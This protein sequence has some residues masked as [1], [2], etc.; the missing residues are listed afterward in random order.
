MSISYFELRQNLSLRIAMPASVPYWRIAQMRVLLVDD[1][2]LARVT[3]AAGLRSLGLEVSEAENGM[4]A[5]QLWTVGVF[6]TVITDI[7]M[8]EL[9]GYELALRIRTMDNERP[10]LPPI[11]LVAL[12]GIPT[13]PIDRENLGQAFD[14]ILEKPIRAKTL[15]DLIQQ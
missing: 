6:G 7:M 15:F 8:P 4:E 3:M 14:L 13:N 12:S 10:D 9:D 11:R 2:R 5:L 1:N